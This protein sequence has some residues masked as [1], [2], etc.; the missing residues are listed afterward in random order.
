MQHKMSL[1]FIFIC[2]GYLAEM[3]MNAGRIFMID[4][5]EINNVSPEEEGRDAT[6]ISAV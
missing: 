4:K 5:V 6:H 2:H 3:F 1:Y